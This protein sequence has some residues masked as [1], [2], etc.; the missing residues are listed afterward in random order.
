MLKGGIFL[1]YIFNSTSLD[2]RRKFRDFL[3][4]GRAVARLSDIICLEHG[5]YIIEHPKRYTHSTYDKW[6]GETAKPSNRDIVRKA[7]DEILAQKPADFEMFLNFLEKSGFSVKRGKQ[8]SVTHPDF[9][10]AVR[11][12]SLGDGYTEDD[13]RAVLSREKQHTPRK[14]KNALAPRKDSLLIDIEAKL[15]EGK[16]VGFERRIYSVNAAKVY[17]LKQMAQTVNYLR[18]QGLLNYDDLKQK[19]ADASA[20]YFALSDRIKTAEKRLAELAV[21]KTYIINYAK[22]REVY[23]GYRKTGYSKKYLAEHEGDILLHKAAKNA[24]VERGLKKLPTVMALQAEYAE[25]LAE[26]KAAY[27]EYRTARDEM[28]ALA[29]HKANVEQILGMAPER[30][31]KKNEHN[32]G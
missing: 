20:R 3:G 2:C 12:H 11:L 1:L 6:L 5:L 22:T 17:N 31:E 29:I 21:L 16:G 26:K 14:R 7:I 25:L 23:A 15:R 9:K 4:S 28:R 10:K 13:I 24:L 32:R 30:E 27:A 19:S 18:E 8:I